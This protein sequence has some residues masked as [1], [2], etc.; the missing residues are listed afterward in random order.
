MP[1]L[2]RIPMEPERNLNL[3]FREDNGGQRMINFFHIDNPGQM[4]PFFAVNPINA[5]PRPEPL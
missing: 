4:N 3:I 2:Q 1:A 5:P